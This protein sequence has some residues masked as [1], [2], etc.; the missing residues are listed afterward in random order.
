MSEP[1]YLT[2]SRYLRRRHGCTVYRVAVDAGFT[3]PNRRSGRES[4]GCTYCAGNGSR[5]AYLPA[6]ERAV[7]CGLGAAGGSFDRE[8][9]ERQIHAAL[10]FLRRR[11]SAEAFILFF[12]AYSNTNA[13]V[14][15]LAQ[16]YDAGLAAASFRGLSVATRPDCLDQEKARL[17]ASYR[18]RGL[19]VWAELGLQSA[20]DRT[21]RR[22]GRGHTAEDFR[23]AFLLLKKHGV[24]VGVHLIF[25]LPGESF[26]DM[27]ETIA[28][29]SRLSPDGVKIHNLL[30]HRDSP[31]AREML[32]GEITAPA[33]A[34]HLEYTL[35]A[36]ER[37]PA[38]TVIMRIT[39]DA[40]PPD[41]A[42]PRSFWTKGEFT[43]RL[44]A[45]MNARGARQGRLFPSLDLAI[46][47]G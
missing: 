9:L 31:L 4:G 34:R 15:T 39:T 5:A 23:R 41:I 30:I 2:Y 6:E 16:V 27:M 32:M 21:L 33:A 46:P 17:L 12:Q 47:I 1:P 42:A 28:L 20:H 35:A 38:D 11:Y 45:E 7:V 40:L 3:C 14:E 29:V 18:D 19:E 13:P 22:I 10:S 24:K 26:D 44:A 36:I 25:G 43:S 37:L 8:A